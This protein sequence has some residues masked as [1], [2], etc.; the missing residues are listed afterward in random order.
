MLNSKFI[1]ATIFSL[2]TLATQSHAINVN[3]NFAVGGPDIAVGEQV[4]IRYTT[5]NFPEFMGAD[6]FFS[7]DDT[8][9]S[10]DSAAF[11]DFFLTS[12]SD[13]PAIGPLAV[14]SSSSPGVVTKMVMFSRFFSGNVSGDV[15]LF[16]LNFTGVGA[17]TSAILMSESPTAPFATMAGPLSETVT[18]SQPSVTVSA[19]PGVIPLPASAVMLLG[20]LAATA[21][22]RRT[23]REKTAA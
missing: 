2:C 5:E 6:L 16:D 4:T 8:V 12:V 3:S 22:T 9:L 14:P 19:A 15:F 11:G 7:F 18:F 21:A 23:A 20:A 1:L 17:G 10:F 13:P